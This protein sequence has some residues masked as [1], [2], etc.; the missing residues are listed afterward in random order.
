M[1]RQNDD[2]DDDDG[3]DDHGKDDDARR[4]K[5][6]GMG[7]LL[8]TREV[9]L[10]LILLCMSQ[11]LNKLHSAIV[12]P[13]ASVSTQGNGRGSIPALFQRQV[14]EGQNLHGKLEEL[15]EE[16]RVSPAPGALQ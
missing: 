5:R 8:L 2:D 15:R 9:Y 7:M 16:R 10:L 11:I 14:L 13:A 4:R 3:K 12:L 1:V 6:M